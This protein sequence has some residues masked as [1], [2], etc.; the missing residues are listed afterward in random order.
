MFRQIA[1]FALATAMLGL[2]TG[3]ASIVNG[4]KKKV[5]FNTEP[6]G[7]QM[8]LTNATGQTVAEGNTPLTVQ[9][10][11]GQKYFK[12]EVFQLAIC[13]AGYQDVTKELHA[14]LNGWYFGNFGFGGLLGLLVV[15]PLTGAMWTLP[16]EVNVSLVPMQ[17]AQDPNALPIV[18]LDAVPVTLRSRMVRIN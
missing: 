18:G 12:G 7:A 16:K 17:A 8:K 9:L 13:K 10:R 15:D 3:C 14:T 5:T 4:G 2:G 1:F 11:R 6:S